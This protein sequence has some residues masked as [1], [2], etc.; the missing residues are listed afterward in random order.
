MNTRRGQMIPRGDRKWLLR[1]YLG[2]DA[3]RKRQYLAKTFEGTTSQA[4]TELTKMQRDQDTGSIV[5]PGK[6]TLAGF[7]EQWYATKVKIRDSTL[8][9]YKDHLNLYIIPHLGHLKLHEVTPAIVQAM[10]KKLIEQRLS[11]RTIEYAHTV[12]HQVCE[13]AVERGFL[14]RN[15]TDHTERPEKVS[16]DFTI[17]SPDQML[18]LFESE[19]GKKLLPLWL[20]MCNTGLRPG[21]A[22]ALRWSNLDGDTIRVQQVLERQD[23]GGYKLVERQAKT[24][25]S[26]F[27]AITLPSSVLDA[28]KT[29]RQ[30]Q[31][32]QMLKAGERYVRNDFIF[33]ARFGSFLDPN[34]VRNRFKTAL[35]RAKLPKTVRLYDTR[36]SHATMLLNDCNA[37]LAWVADR[38][39]H[40]STRVTEAIYTRILPESRRELAASLEGAFDKAKAKKAA[41]R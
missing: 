4:L 32:S 18:T 26:L 28:L 2:L 35:K 30:Q 41:A 11:P 21:E 13:K 17:L 16:R 7:I 20:L 8:N 9:G 33:A 37:N 3:N 36:H 38:L 19:K 15:P 12:L 40:S 29:H 1:V 5:R 6:Q 14:V 22:L 34:N 39:G 24:K 23:K 25:K 27:R 31:V 10:V